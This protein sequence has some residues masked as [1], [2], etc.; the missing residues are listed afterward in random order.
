MKDKAVQDLAEIRHLMESSSRYL[1]L[2]GWAGIW[3]G[4]FALIGS[5]IGYTKIQSGY[6]MYH[7]DLIFELLPLAIAVLILSVL[8]GVFTSHRKAK[9]DNNALF[10]SASKKLI[11]KFGSILIIGG[12]FG[13]LLIYRGMFDLV[14]ASTLLF[15]GLA[16]L[17]VHHLTYSSVKY[18]G[19]YFV[20][21]G[22]IS[23]ANPG[24]GIYLWPLGFGIGHIVYGILFLTKEQKI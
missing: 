15:Y 16:I 7:S 23:M 12:L 13:L 19:Y 17:S 4:L 6:R 22:L 8:V 18:L 1:S 21:L 5:F 20:L 24:W 11:F 9:R 14:G 2:S 10:N 3:A